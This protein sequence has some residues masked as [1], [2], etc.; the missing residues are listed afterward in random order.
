MKASVWVWCGLLAAMVPAMAFG[1]A[2]RIPE[3]RQATILIRALA[4][5]R[6]AGAKSDHFTVAVL[7]KAGDAESRSAAAAMTAAFRALSTLTMN[8]VPLSVVQLDYSGPEALRTAFAKDEVRAAY[9]PA[10]LTDALAAI[11]GV[12]RSLGV[13]S[14]A[15]DEQGVTSGL[16]LAVIREENRPRIIFNPDA[17]VAEHA[18]FSSDL[19]AL[20]RV[21]K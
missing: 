4:Y 19:L 3:D 11:K 18:N 14:I 5:N 12:T 9:V 16:T 15:S 20:V 1:Q 17:A 10:S 13:I 6:A 2:D 8:G 21:V 7:T